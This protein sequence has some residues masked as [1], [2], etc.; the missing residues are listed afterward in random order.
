VDEFSVG[1][2]DARGGKFSNFFLKY[3]KF[4]FNVKKILK[5]IYLKKI[6]IK[7]TIA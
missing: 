4:K 1:V 5:T 2:F 3:Q 7:F 6:S